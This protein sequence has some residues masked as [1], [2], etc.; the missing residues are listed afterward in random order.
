MCPGLILLA[1]HAY[2]PSYGSTFQKLIKDEYGL[3]LYIVYVATY[4]YGTA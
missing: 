2:K 4:M 1:Y 3:K